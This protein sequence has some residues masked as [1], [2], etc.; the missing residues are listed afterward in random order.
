MERYTVISADCHAGADLLDYREYLDPQYRDEFDGWAS[1]YVNPFSD[2]TEPDAERNW[3]SDRRNTD[4]DSEG[5]AGEVIYPNTVP[6]FFP[7]ASLAAPRQ[8]PPASSNCAGPGSART[9]AG[10]PTSARCHRS[11][12]LGWARSCSATSTK[13]SPR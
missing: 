11:G 13:L 12:A 2:L 10:W 6:P 5:I 9:I 8:R 1:T 7:Q 3:N 4:L